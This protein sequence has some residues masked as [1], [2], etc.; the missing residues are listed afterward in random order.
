MFDV[1]LYVLDTLAD[2]EIG[3]LMPEINTGRFFRKDS[4]KPRIH[5]AGA[6]MDPVTTMGGFRIT[7][8]CLVD[9]VPASKDAMLILPGSDR[10]NEPENFKAVSKAREVLDAGGRVCA[11]CGAT[12]ALA[13]A[14][15]LDSIKHTSNGPGFLEMVCPAYKGGGSYVDEPAVI[16][17]GLITAA[18]T[19][20]IEW[21]RLILRELDVMKPAA[22]E[23]WFKYFST[24][25][26]QAYFDLMN[27]V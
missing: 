23:A 17:S 8:D 6:S 14:G 20:S 27:A 4:G 12:V 22:L 16:D 1:Y 2:W 3:L 13:Y 11:I 21:T 10:W 19:G 7:P 26:A 24:G 9:D 15:M 18:G 5:L 25:D